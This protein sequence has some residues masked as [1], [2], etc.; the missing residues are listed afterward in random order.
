MRK[1]IFLLILFIVCI[2]GSGLFTI[3]CFGLSD[4]IFKSISVEDLLNAIDKEENMIVYYGQEECSACISFSEKL[5]KLKKVYEKE[6]MYLDADSLNTTEKQVLSEFYVTQTPTLIILNA[7]TPFFY[8]N[9]DSLDDIEIAITKTD[10][11]E[12]RIDELVAINYD[13]IKKKMKE[14]LDFFLY[15]GR[16]DCRDCV[17][18][19]PILKKYIR[20]TENRGLYYFDIKQY[21]DL[22]RQDGASNED[23]ELYNI[24]KEQFNITWV[25]SVYHIRNGMIIAKYEFLDEQFYELDEHKQEIEEKY[26]IEQLYYWM[27]MEFR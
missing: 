26:Y 3:N 8:R 1:K 4:T 24:I 7:G 21:R 12:D 11:T 6:V 25:P 10:I 13:D 15:I 16:E 19:T 22:A 18:F 20:E 9:I 27:D 17:K 5:K 2:L 14:G 23:I